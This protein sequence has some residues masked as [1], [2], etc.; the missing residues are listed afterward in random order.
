MGDLIKKSTNKSYSGR[1][2]V[3]VEGIT[4]SVHRGKNASYGNTPV[5]TVNGADIP[6][7]GTYADVVKMIRKFQ[8]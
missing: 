7:T 2:T 6:V 3:T 1:E 5:I 8:K 4:Y